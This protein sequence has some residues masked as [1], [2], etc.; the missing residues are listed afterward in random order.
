MLSII[1][2]EPTN[3]LDIET[4]DALCDAINDYNGGVVCVTHDARLIEATRMRLWV[5][6]NRQV[7]EWS[8]PFEAYREHLLE[9][10]E[11]VCRL[12]RLCHERIIDCRP[13]PRKISVLQQQVFQLT[14]VETEADTCEQ[15]A[16]VIYWASC[17]SVK[18]RPHGTN[19][20][21][22]LSLAARHIGSVLPTKSRTNE[23]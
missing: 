22:S 6:Q 7:T 1:R 15:I 11:K 17:D 12:S 5:V 3:N 13:W 2:A 4:I 18:A 16:P 23:S 19:L 14:W 20:A 9:T 10:L 21:P 8:E